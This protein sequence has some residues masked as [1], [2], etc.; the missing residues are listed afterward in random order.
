[1]A[2][3]EGPG[4]PRRRRISRPARRLAEVLLF[5]LVLHFLVLPQ[6]GGTRRAIDLLGE[7]NPALVAAGI[8]LQVGSLLAYAQLTR[9]LL[10]G[11]ERPH[12]WTQARITLSTRGFSNVVPGGA[13]SATVLGFR[14]LRANGVSGTS[15]TFAMATQSIGSAVVLN[16]LLWLGLVITIPTRGFDPLY[17]IAA[18]IGALI[19]GGFF[20]L[21]LAL[22][23]GRRQA[24]DV[25]R[26][27]AG[28]I[29]VLDEDGFPALLERIADNMHRLVDDRRVLVTA[30]GWATTNWLL[31]VA[32]LGVFLAAFGADVSPEALLV[33]FGLANV[34][35]AVPITP[36]GLGVIEATLTAVL[37]G[38]GAPAAAAA[39]GVAAYRLVNYWAVIPTGVAAYLSLKVSAARSPDEPAEPVAEEAPVD[40]DEPSRQRLRRWASTHGVRPPLP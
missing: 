2:G 26:R 25:A 1:M 21:V 22:T 24:L 34:L 28:R 15:T 18:V 29:P 36:G 5:A 31:D 35:A 23:R 10:P 4:T 27:I 33:A 14:L 30:V 20:A 12:L 6:L 9:S 17:T 13:A 40:D 7:V 19:L 38:F 8:A 37:V 39:L 16:L 32:S 11:S 3:A